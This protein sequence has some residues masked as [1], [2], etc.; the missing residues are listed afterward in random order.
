MKDV[1]TSVN[2]C[3]AIS[4]FA[5]LHHFLQCKF[6]PEIVMGSP[7]MNCWLCVVICYCHH[8][9]LSVLTVNVNVIDLISGYHVLQWF[10][11]LVFSV[12]C[13]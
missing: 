3:S 7:A 11:R 1:S 12:Q 2:G 10:F 6:N 13:I 8:H 9:M 5:I 4:A